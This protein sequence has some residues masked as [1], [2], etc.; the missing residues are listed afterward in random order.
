MLE[1]M[2]KDMKTLIKI[3]GI[4]AGIIA[5]PIVLLFSFFYFLP[6]L[7]SGYLFLRFSIPR[8]S[9]ITRFH[10]Y[11]RDIL[12]NGGYLLYSTNDSCEQVFQFYEKKFQ[13]GKWTLLESKESG[14]ISHRRAKNFA[15]LG[16]GSRKWGAKKWA[17]T[18]ECAF[19]GETA[20]GRFDIG[21]NNL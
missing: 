21:K 6:R 3:V 4:V 19:N 9:N 16:E 15:H 12:G 13:G 10:V 2:S 5:I 18:L 1:Y 8:Y 11:P 17:V 7:D 14:D 20:G